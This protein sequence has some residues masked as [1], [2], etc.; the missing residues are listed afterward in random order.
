MAG[1]DAVNQVGES[2]CG[3]LRDR[4]NLL[5]AEGRL[6][7]VPQALEIVQATTGRLAASPVPTAGLTLTC[8][9]LALSEHPPARPAA[10]GQA[11]GI[12]VALEI[13]YLLAA[14]AGT[15]AEEQGVLAWAMLE[16][17]R[18]PT[19]DRSVLLGGVWERQ[20]SVQI[21]PE[22]L[23]R[24]ELFRIWSA[25]GVRYRLSTTFRARVVRI[26]Y[27]PGAVWPPVVAT[28]MGLAATDPLV[29]EAT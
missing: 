14:W 29:P 20:E 19:L 25:L 7:P 11:E 10:R 21:V 18:Y 2:L 5:A 6:G 3:L 24:D 27:G 17:T 12:S 23:D 28:R 1:I 15:P 8:Y 16:L 13:G 9:S 26:G 4:R 22:T